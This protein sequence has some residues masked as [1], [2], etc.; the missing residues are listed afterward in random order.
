MQT[1]LT[2]GLS[3]SN[4]KFQ[5]EIRFYLAVLFL[6]IAFFQAGPV[7][8]K[9]A[10]IASAPPIL[11]AEQEKIIKEE[12]LKFLRENPDRNPGEGWLFLARHYNELGQPDKSINLIKSI[13][14]A[15]PVEPGLKFEAQLLLV[16]IL[17][18]K[19]GTR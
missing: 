5:T 10:R 7:E 1:Q 19:K 8:A 15:V 16:D 4:S 3:K 12:V 2:S 13:V 9:K 17:K 11:E 6:V 18:E 14:R